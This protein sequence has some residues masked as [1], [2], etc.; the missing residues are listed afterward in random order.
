MSLDK[1]KNLLS[2]TTISNKQY[3]G[4]EYEAGYHTLKIDD[5]II[6][7]QR[8]P[9][10]RF[11]GINFDFNGKTVLDIGS[12]Q[13][14]ML[15]EI[16][17]KIKQ[18]VGVDFDYKLVNVSNRISQ[19]HNYNNLKFYFFD[20]D[21]EDFNLLNNFSDEKY[22]VVFLL[23]VCMWIKSWKELIKWVYEN[24][25]YCLF[26]TNG[27]KELQRDQVAYLKSLYFSVELIHKSSQDDPKQKKRSTYW[28]KK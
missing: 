24:S 23:A 18:G 14:G 10:Q 3:N 5:T 21:N 28:C 12:N 13:G 7:G 15:Y 6:K 26:E 11:E 19:Y 9:G 20:A 1:I 4:G 16:Q 27:K 25:N 22:D 2:Y 8:N 17:N